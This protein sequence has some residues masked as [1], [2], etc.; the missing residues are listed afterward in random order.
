MIRWIV[1]ST[2]R[3]APVMV[4]AAAVLLFLGVY[5]T[6]HARVDALPEFG[7]ASVQ[8][9]TEAV[10]LS[11]SEVEQFITVPMEDELNGIAYLDQIH[12]RSIPGLSAIDLTFKPGTDLL[13]ARQLVT[14]RLAQGPGV[15][16]V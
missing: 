13:R 6:Q 2:V 1:G 16:N 7:S 8:V 12:S 5:Q 11:A 4:A 10:G 14:E 3:L 15:A 9:Q